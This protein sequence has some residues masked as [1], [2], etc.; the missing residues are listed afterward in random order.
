MRFAIFVALLTL[1]APALAQRQG[2][3]PIEAPTQP[4]Q[5]DPALAE[6]IER[7]RAAVAQGEARAID[8]ELS[9]DYATFD[10][11]L[12]PTRACARREPQGR[13]AERERKRYA[14]MKPAQR[15]RQDLCCVDIA[16]HRITPKLRDE[17]VL[18]AIGAALEEETLGVSPFDAAHVCAPAPP[19][20]DRAAA[21][22]AADRA[23]IER[24]ELR[25]TQG[26]LTL[27]AA[28]R[29]DAPGIA[30]LP[31]RRVVPLAT[32]G[33]GALPDGWSAVVLPD[34]RLGYTDVA[35]L[36]ELSYAGICFSRDPAGRWRIGAAVERKP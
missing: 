29:R 18:G 36:G 32:G 1:A 31:P 8:A 28:P 22:L 14:A 27:R 13:R 21:A 11:F 6:L 19:H 25:V 23:D 24:E 17:A 30:D 2:Y 35:A 7:L 34:G 20:F 5:A 26:P 12:D 4:V 15:I 3:A 10:C 16:P 9:P 33:E